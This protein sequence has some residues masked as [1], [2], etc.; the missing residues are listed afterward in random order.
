LQ[1]EEL[2]FQSQLSNE[3]QAEKTKLDEQI[4]AAKLEVSMMKEREQEYA[5]LEHSK[6]QE[7][8]SLKTKVDRLESLLKSASEKLKQ[9]KQELRSTVHKH[10][11]EQAV[12]AAGLR[13]LL[14]M[15]NKELKRIKGLAELILEQRSEV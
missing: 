1:R 8:L 10:L 5:L 4:Y 14:L 13:H 11:H 15:K 3:L 9:Q 6:K 2:K 12:D 7:V